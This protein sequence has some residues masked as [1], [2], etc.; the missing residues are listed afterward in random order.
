LY[1]RSAIARI[2]APKSKSQRCSWCQRFYLVVPKDR[3][4]YDA[5]LV[6]REGTAAG[7]KLLGILKEFPADDS[8][9]QRVRAI[10]SDS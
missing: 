4:V 9:L 10:L 6:W 7:L 2:P 5:E 8:N 1:A 3:L